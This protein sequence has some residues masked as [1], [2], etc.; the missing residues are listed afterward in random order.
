MGKMRYWRKE[1]IERELDQ[2]LDYG[3]LKVTPNSYMTAEKFWEGYVIKIDGKII[4]ELNS[5]EEVM[6]AMDYIRFLFDDMEVRN[7]GLT[8]SEYHKMEMRTSEEYE[9]SIDDCLD[10]MMLHSNIGNKEEVA[11]YRNMIKRKVE[12]DQK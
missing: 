12:A 6:Y 4:I 1:E 9:L 10:L 7:E 8:E 3:I 11:R 2:D 5:E